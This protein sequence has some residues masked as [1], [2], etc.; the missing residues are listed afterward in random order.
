[1]YLSRIRLCTDSNTGALARQLCESDSYREHQMLWQLFGDN[2]DAKRD[3][4]FRRDDHNGWP[5]FYLLSKRMPEDR[6]HIW[7]I[8]HKEYQPKLYKEQKLAFSLRANPVITRKDQ[9]GKSKRH[10]LVMDLKKKSDWKKTSKN[11]RATIH[12][13][14]R[15][16]GETWLTPRLERNGA[17]LQTLN[18]DG[19][20]QHLNRKKSQKKAIRYSTLD[21]KG[22]LSVTDPEIFTKAL[23]QGIG[24]AKAFG[25]G[26]LLIRRL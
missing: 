7:Q 14:A 5:L 21:L 26:L 6:N 18:V 13:L 17:E 12:A 8:D 10:D 22:T 23:F 4:L 20:I 19:Y 25:C 11:D 9:S 2:P 1:M 3:F 24:P 16:A 15:Q